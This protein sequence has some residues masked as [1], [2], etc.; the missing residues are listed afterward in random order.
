MDG[1]NSVNTNRILGEDSI[2]PCTALGCMELIDSVNVDVKGKIA[3]VV[4]KG[5]LAGGPMASLLRLR[6]AAVVQCDK[7]TRNLPDI[8]RAAEVLVVAI[9]VPKFIKGEWIKQ[10]SVVIDCGINT[11][12]GKNLL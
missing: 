2:V 11:Y 3:V 6:E 12:I 10:G 4:G 9:G 7:R 1:L 5:K 8:C